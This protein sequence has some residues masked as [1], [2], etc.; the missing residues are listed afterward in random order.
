MFATIKQILNPKNKDMQKRLLFTFAILF[1]FRLGAAIVVPGINKDSLMGN[2]G[3][4]QLINVMGG[5]ALEK[6]S[7]FSLGVMPY[8]TASIIMQFLEKDI[9]P[10]FSELAKQGHTGRSKLNQ[11][12][13]IMGI[14]LAFI[15]GFIFSFNYINNGTVFQYMEYS[16]IL[17]AGTAFLIWLGDQITAKGIGNGL[18]II[19]MAGILSNLP[20]MFITAY[21]ALVVTTSVQ[22]IFIGLVSFGILVLLYIGIVLGVIYIQSA[23]RRLPIQ[24]A[25]KSTST[26]GR[27]NYIPFKLNTSGVMPVILA[28]TLFGVIGLLITVFKNETVTLFYNKWIAYTTPTGLI[29]YAVLIFAFA[30]FYTFIQ[31]N[32]KEMSD[33]LEKSGG[34][35]PGIR[36][37]EETIDYVT[38]VLKKITVVGTFFLTLIAVLPILFGLFSTLPTSVTVGGTGLLIVVGVALEVYKQL[39]STLLSRSYTKGRRR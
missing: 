6:F 12:T 18:S 30:Y 29:L 8:I 24:Y 10:Y 5:G 4:L 28:S 17:T 23:E 7:I 26:L 36:P 21:Q 1:V 19:I 34:Y 38:K 32:P 31:I 13:R 35:I 14:F 9:I 39:E 33:D 3:L 2:I 16:V 27:Q 11:I 25:N 22:T 20:V 15:Q 37:G